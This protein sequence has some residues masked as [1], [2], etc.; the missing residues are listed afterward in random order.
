MQAVF[1]ILAVAVS[2]LCLGPASTEDV[3]K[4]A[5][6]SQVCKD[7]ACKDG[8]CTTCCAAKCDATARAR[9]GESILVAAGAKASLPLAG[10]AADE[11]Y[12]VT[13]WFPELQGLAEADAVTAKILDASGEVVSKVLHGGDP[14]LYITLKPR[15]SGDGAVEVTAAG[16]AGKTYELR[17]VCSKMKIDAGAGILIAAQPN[18]TWRS[19][20]PIELGKT[21]FASNDERPYIPPLGNAET[22][23]NSLVAGPQ[24]FTFTHA[25]P[26]PVLV[27]FMIDMLDRDVPVDITVFTRQGQGAGEKMVP[28]WEGVERHIPEQSNSF[29]GLYKFIARVI[30]PG[31]YYVRTMGNHPGYQIRTD[32]YD[33]PPYSDPGKAIR[34]GMDFLVKK[35]DSWHANT[36]RRGSVVLR[37]SNPLGETRQCIACH[38]THFTTRGEL[39]A[40]ENG[41]PVK[42]RPSLQFLTER[43]YNNPRPIYG[44][45]DAVWARMISAPGSVFGRLGYMLTNFEKDVSHEQ[46]NDFLPAIANYLEMFWKGVDEPY[47]DSNG[48]LPHVSGFQMAL[49][50]GLVF[51][52]MYNRTRDEK[53]ANL[54][55][56]MEEGIAKTKPIDMIDLC[57]KAVALTTFNKAKHAAEIQQLVDEIFSYQKADGTWSMVF[58]NDVIHHDYHTGTNNPVQAP[59]GSDGA[60]LYS[61]FQTYHCI[62]ALAK[63]GVPADDPRLAKAVAWCLSR[64]WS[65]GGWQGNADYKNFDTPFR[66]TQFAVMALS[67]LYKVPG[68]EGW[69]AGFPSVPKDFD[70]TDTA[71][72]LAALDQYWED[73]GPDVRAKVRGVLEHEQPLVRFAAASAVGRLADTE[74]I[75]E[76]VKLLGDPSKMVQRGAAWALRQIGSRRYAGH[77]EILAALSSKDDRTRWGA[78]RIF[79]QHFKYMAE[80]QPIAASLKTHLAEDP[81]PSIR[82]E[83]AQALWQW[84]YWTRSEDEKGGI[85]DAFVTQMAKA[86]HPWVRR[87]LIE[88]FHNMEDDNEAYFYNSWVRQVND[89][90]DKKMLTDGHHRVVSRQ[91]KRIGE[92][93]KNGNDLVRDGI[94]RSYYTFHLRES[95]GDPAVVASVPIPETFVHPEPTDRGQN[96]WMDGYKKYAAYDPLTMGSG[97]MAGIGNDHAPAVYYPESAPDVAEGLLAV[98]NTG[99]PSL[100]PGVLKALKHSVGVP[101]DEPFSTKLISLAL[102][103]V[104]SAADEVRGLVRELLPDRITDG[105]ESRKA[106][107]EAIK[108]GSASG[109]QLAEAILSNPRND[110]MAGSTEVSSALKE[111][112]LATGLDD[113]QLASLMGAMTYSKPLLADAEVANRFAAAAASPVAGNQ[114]KAVRVMLLSPSI[115]AAGDARDRFETSLAEAAPERMTTLLGAASSLDYSKIDDEAGVSLALGIVT[116]GLRHPDH[117]VRA[118]ALEDVRTITKIQNNPAVQALI[119]DLGSDSDPMVQ[120]SAQALLAS[121]DSRV[122]LAKQDVTQL[123]DYRFFVEQV[124][125]ILEKEGSDKTACVKCH[126]NHSVFRLNRPGADGT[127]T[128]A[129]LRQN[130][131]AALKVVDPASPEASLV[132]I[133]PTKGFEGIELPGSYRKTHG[134][135][136]RWAA[137]RESEEYR[138]ILR[139]IQ[140]ARVE[141]SEH[142]VLAAA[143]PVPES[144]AALA[145]VQAAVTVSPPASGESVGGLPTCPVMQGEPIDFTVSVATDEGPVFFCCAHCKKKYCAQPEKFAECV[146]LQRKQL[147]KLAK[148]QVVC[149]VSGKAVDPSV[150]FDGPN[151]KVAFCCGNCCAAYQKDPAKFAAKLANCFTYQTVCPV[152]GKPINPAI[153]LEV[154][155]GTRIYFCCGGCCGEYQKDPDKYA[156]KLKEMGFKIPVKEEAAQV[157]AAPAPAPEP[158]AAKPVT[159]TVPELVNGLPTCVV[160]KGAPVNF[161]VSAATDQGP[162]FFC[163]ENCRKGF[164]QDP[165]KYSDQVAAQRL[166]LASLPK[167]QVAC[168][169][170]KKAIDP[171]VTMDYQGAKVAFCCGGCLEK[172]RKTPADFA[173][174]LA[175]SFT[176]QTVCPVSGKPIC[177]TAALDVGG[178]AKIYFCCD[179]CKKSFAA[180]PAKYADKLKAMG[181]KMDVEKVTAATK[182]AANQ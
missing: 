165:S 11:Y 139:W 124:Q 33:L 113:P 163:C 119:H 169:V 179:G 84:W 149:P 116:T 90:G 39:I 106:L 25:G 62:Y 120:Q 6:P 145:V 46:R 160:N 170:S 18:S 146:A 96:T 99:A 95:G 1:L 131:L 49:H 7:A 14:D 102:N 36:P 150:T 159:E 140:G 27:H 126:A 98:L 92:A 17:A 65:N 3:P 16:L 8:T 48:N 37:A 157:A 76:L 55:S 130:Y 127:L 89:E 71:S 82:M 133:K 22:T 155:E 143:K 94:L 60:P 171:A 26:K 69:M 29:H 5:A 144:P 141:S 132:L 153:S 100:Q 142:I 114:E 164:L 79:N 117:G 118:K 64:Q 77:E 74:A 15:K 168:P 19:A 125:P 10:L 87:N 162:V 80:R 68:G 44:N 129:Q 178:D 54:R 151:G 30:R 75:P 110:G 86:E 40:I 182:V 97:V 50:G 134:G 59:T 158:A 66:D 52:E 56:Q 83:A 61:E 167:V 148:V 121:F 147:A 4:P 103:P 21:V 81:V 136:V 115:L 63:A 88:G 51:E 67:E 31:T 93:L 91:A 24:W 12:G 85:E 135:N 20:Q 101:A 38:P 177:P 105:E 111:K 122:T 174:S 152:S 53:Y 45:P 72:T 128:D 109:L 175:N 47:T 28:Y 112:F 161:A 73:P 123:L 137:K 138:T 35:G 173:A 9:A 104:S 57:W 43:L 34:A 41:Y 78:A 176:Y 166:Q 154:A 13:V 108:A 181:I 107:T 2:T 180:D 172:F 58:A 42:A 70:A 32:I 23:F 156:A